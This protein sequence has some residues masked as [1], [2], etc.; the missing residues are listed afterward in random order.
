MT[1]KIIQFLFLCLFTYSLL[2]PVTYT[3]IKGQNINGLLL[4]ASTAIDGCPV[5]EWK[6]QPGWN[7]QS[8]SC[9]VGTTCVNEPNNA[10]AHSAPLNTGSISVNYN[11][12]ANT[13][14]PFHF[15]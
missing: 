5:G 10:I 13:T 8:R 2:F 4:W 9:T 3:N 6:Q 12:P 1:S 11:V 15:V 14:R 7:L